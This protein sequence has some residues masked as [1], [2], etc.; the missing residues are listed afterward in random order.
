MNK[1]IF[2]AA[3]DTVI[4]AVAENWK[5]IQFERDNNLCVQRIIIENI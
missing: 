2:L 3:L 4:Y 1:S 5:K